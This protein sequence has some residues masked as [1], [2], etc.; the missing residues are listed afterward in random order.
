VPKL[1]KIQE[2]SSHT[3]HTGTVQFEEERS[4]VLCSRKLSGELSTEELVRGNT[5][6]FV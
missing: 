6:R 1:Q 4:T 3:E 5:E 2:G